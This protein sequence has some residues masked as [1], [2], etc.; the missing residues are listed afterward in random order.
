VNDSFNPAGFFAESYA[1][2]RATFRN[3]AGE[4]GWQHEVQPIEGRGPS[5]EE[6]AI[7]IAINRQ[8]NDQHARRCLVV[9]SGLHGV[10]AFLGSALQCAA[11]RHWIS[12]PHTVPKARCV[13]LHVLNP[14]GCAHLRRADENNIDLNRNFLLD[15]ELYRGSPPGYGELDRFL[16]PKCP[17]R[18]WDA[19]TLQALARIARVGLPALKAAIAGGQFDFP[20]GLFYG[21]AHASQTKRIVAGNLPRWL[22]DARHV[23]HI[24][25]H[26]GLGKW[27][28]YKLLVD[29][30]LTADQR[31]RL[32]DWFGTAA[33]EENPEDANGRGVAYA[34]RGG[35]G[36][37]CM[38]TQRE[39]DYLFAYAEFGVYNILR[40]IAGLRAENQAHFW[41]KAD[42]VRTQRAKLRL[43]ELL[44][45]AAPAWRENAVQ[46]GIEL[47]T[48]AADGLAHLSA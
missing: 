30:A 11:M 33:F 36:Q 38:T 25:L 9:S 14:Y 44:C 22:A 2:A 10:E 17:P 19:F 23:M 18:R 7:D 21:G 15:G 27:G 43:K 29:Y 48:R 28:S 26:A 42:D 3:L 41:A 34:T 6:L 46:Q 5:G 37:W 16:N 1:Q 32:A 47:I 4:L 12:H 39:R 45:P 20:Q 31:K 40:T 24:D 13:F 35:F 8:Q